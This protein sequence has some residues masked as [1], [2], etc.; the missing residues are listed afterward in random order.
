MRGL[1][2]VQHRL[3]VRGLHQARPLPGEHAKLPRILLRHSA[4]RRVRGA[5]CA[6][7][8]RHLG[9]SAS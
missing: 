7:P 1:L 8:R 5:E 2:R 3:P 6:G 4:G 9:H